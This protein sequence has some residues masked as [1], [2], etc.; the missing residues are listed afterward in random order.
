MTRIAKTVSVNMSVPCRLI[1]TDCPHCSKWFPTK[2]QVAWHKKLTCKE[3]KEMMKSLKDG[4]SDEYLAE[5]AKE[6]Q[7]K[8]CPSCSFYVQRISGCNRRCR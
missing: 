5:L 7:W 8:R 6:M 4:Q 1:L 2:I 3:F